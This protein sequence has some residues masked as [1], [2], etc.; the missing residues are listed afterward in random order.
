MER[1]YKQ[2][3]LTIKL[4]YYYTNNR[5]YFIE[6]VNNTLLKEYKNSVS[7]DESNNISCDTIL[8]SNDES[9]SLLTH[10]KIVR[11]Y[12]NLYTPYRGLL[13][14][15]GLGSGKT[16]TSIAIAEGLKS[17]KQIIILTP[18]SLQKNY[19]EELKKCGD[20]LYKQDQ[21]WEWVEV[22]TIS[23]AESLQKIIHL[24]ADVIYRKK[25]CWLVNIKK[26]SNFNDLSDKDKTS[27]T[28]QINKMIENKYIFINYNGLRENKFKKLT[29]NY[30]VNIFDNS[31]VIIDEAHNL[32]SWIVNKINNS[33]NFKRSDLPGPLSLK[34]YEYLLKA[35]NSRI[36][37]LSGTPIINYP[38]E[39]GILFNILRGYIKTWKL[40]CSIGYDKKYDNNY[41]VNHIGKNIGFSDYIFYSPLKKEITITFNPFSFENNWKNGEYNG[42][43]LSKEMMD[44]SEKI[45]K[46]KEYLE[47]IGIIVDKVS[48]ENNVALP[49][50]LEDMTNHFINVGS[51]KNSEQFKKRIIG[52]TS[53]FRSAQEELLPKY[54]KSKDFHVEEI[55]MSNYQFSE[56]EIARNK[57]RGLEKDGQKN[58]EKKVDINGLYIKSASYYKIFSRL[59]CNFVF[60]N[61]P[62]KPNIN[63]EDIE[64]QQKILDEE[65]EDEDE[66]ENEHEDD[67]ENE[68]KEKHDKKREYENK[69]KTVLEYFKNNPDLLR[70]DELKTYSPKFLRILIDIQNSKGLNLVYSVFRTLE[71]IGLFSLVLEANGFV[72]FKIKKTNDKGWIIDMKHEDI[73]KPAYALY[74]GVEKTDEKEIIRNIYNGDWKNLSESIKTTL[75]KISKN[76]NFGEIIKVFMI[77]AS[78]SEGIN[79]RN[80][81]FVR[82]ME[83]Y[84]QP[85]RIEQVIGRARR[86]CSHSQLPKQYQTVEVYIYI[87]KIS[88][89]QLKDPERAILLKQYDTSKLNKNEVF[90]SDQLLYEISSIK[91]KINFE[92]LKAI[93]ETSI[94]CSI[95]AKSNKKEGLVCLNVGHEKNADY[96]YN[97]N[98]SDDTEDKINI[99][100]KKKEE[101]IFQKIVYKK[102]DYMLDTKTQII[103]DYDE[104][105][106]DNKVR[107]GKLENISGK[108]KIIFD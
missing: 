1:F 63:D 88:K 46:L 41:I 83:P 87:M 108:Y 16:C 92:I 77:S 53:Y 17:E 39:I 19:M 30:T 11:D 73:G 98:L 65:N 44:D 43:S 59:A 80:T 104:Y 26:K 48:V 40:K 6:F 57:E 96:M 23:Q 61:P 58:N 31:V 86:I 24:D 28:E 25:G 102:I 52:L 82:I 84:W 107:L 69:I 33:K 34:I 90:T 100:N 70:P 37:L 18:A 76:N 22:N 94:D 10:Q 99:I 67:D 75:Y 103:Y 49:D 15:H 47:K 93:K 81:R 7:N 21:Y 105:K 35:V 12:I 8:N 32:I 29:N 106:N 79:L 14:F 95:Y 50:K 42:V 45:N 74:T 2:D 56:Y 66:D 27:I 89:E 3:K 36:V 54:D 64:I 9:F 4:P 55:I 78:G 72:Q 62:G 60:P 20:V 38:N 51:L 68:N 97:P 101:H 5:E 85:V 91:E 13:L 71:G